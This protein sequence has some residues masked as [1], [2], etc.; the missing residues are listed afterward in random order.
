MRKALAL[1]VFLVLVALV[2]I[3]GF[4]ATPTDAACGN[5]FHCN[6]VNM[7]PNSLPNGQENVPYGPGNQLW[8]TPNSMCLPVIV[9]SVTG[10]LPCGLSFVPVNQNTVALQGTP[11]TGS[12]GV[13]TFTVELGATYVLGT[14]CK[15]S[16]TYTITIIP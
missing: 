12:A 16:Q 5:N 15:V 9:T 6:M 13:Y 2:G 8:L 7:H 11:C 3:G 10:T 1:L 4:S 14:I